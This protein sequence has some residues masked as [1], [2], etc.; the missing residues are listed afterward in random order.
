MKAGSLSVSRLYA[1]E[2]GVTQV[3]DG[4]R[5]IASGFKREFRKRQGKGRRGKSE[6]GHRARQQPQPRPV[7]I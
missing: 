5:G 7:K 3:E 4:S 1:S 6:K 2:N